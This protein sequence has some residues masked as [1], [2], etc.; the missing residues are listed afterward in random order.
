MDT[1]TETK[2][3]EKVRTCEITDILPKTVIEMVKAAPTHET[4]RAHILAATKQPVPTDC[5]THDKIKDWIEYNFKKP[6]PAVPA[7]ELSARV[8]REHTQFG[9]CNFSR[10]LRGE[11]PYFMSAEEMKRVADES[12]NLDEFQDNIVSWFVDGCQENWPDLDVIDGSE[13]YDNYE[14]DEDEGTRNQIAN[15]LCPDAVKTEAV[16]LLYK[17]FP[18]IYRELE[19]E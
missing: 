4:V 8:R 15:V 9:R 1:T 17:H 3:V 5:D 6:V 19:E 2:P 10:R 18:D 11:A 14:E 13:D 12:A 16:K 7:I